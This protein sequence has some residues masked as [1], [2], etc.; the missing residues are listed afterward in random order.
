MITL[1]PLCFHCCG[2]SFLLLT[3]EFALP[4]MEPRCRVG[5]VHYNYKGVQVCVCVCVCVVKVAMTGR[6][7]VEETVVQGLLRL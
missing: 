2:D 5:Y 7:Q 4:V 6:E 1:L 3:V